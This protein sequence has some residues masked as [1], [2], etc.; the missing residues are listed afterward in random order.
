MNTIKDKVSDKWRTPNW[1]FDGLNDTY[2]FFIDLCCSPDNC[3]TPD[4]QFILGDFDYLSLDINS[5]MDKLCGRKSASCAF[6]NPPYSNPKPFI[7]KAYDDSRYC[8]IVCLIKCDPST[9]MWGLFYNFDEN[10]P[11]PGVEV[12]FF[13]FRIQFIPPIEMNAWQEGSVWF[14][15]QNGE[16]KKMPGTP[17]PSCLVV[18]DRRYT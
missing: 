12:T 1:L 9:S 10:K 14:Y 17:F 16:K 6:M 2:N 5:A 7:K 13:N 8:K 11:K 18:F 15:M 4:S 3:K